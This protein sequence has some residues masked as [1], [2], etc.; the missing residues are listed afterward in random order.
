MNIVKRVTVFF[1]IALAFGIAFTGCDISGGGD[2]G[3][4]PSAL[5]AKWY[6]TQA[7]ADLGTGVPILEFT[8]GGKCIYEGDDDETTVRVNRGVITFLV[9]NVEAGKASY[10]ISGTELTIYNADNEDIGTFEGTYYKKAS[11]S[12]GGGS[13]SGKTLTVTGL[14]GY[15]GAPVQVGLFKS[16]DDFDIFAVP[17]VWGG[18]EV[19]NNRAVLSLYQDEDEPWTGSGAWYVGLLIKSFDEIPFGEAWVRSRSV[20]F[21]SSQTV[22]FNSFE[23]RMISFTIQELAEMMGVDL[24][25][26]KELTLN[27]I[28]DFAYEG[29]TDYDGLM[30]SAGGPLFFYDSEHSDPIGGNDT[31]EISITLYSPYVPFFGYEENE[32]GGGDEPG[33]HPS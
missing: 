17:D 23:R 33:F 28:I 7:E 27:E 26:E 30:D 3:Y 4:I 2:G 14:N 13:G 11:G 24:G 16:L 12:G 32:G 9:D 21:N 25:G 20:S 19:A 29:E 5:A 22:A 6:Y 10:N 31:L 18:G 8:L 1:A 15:N